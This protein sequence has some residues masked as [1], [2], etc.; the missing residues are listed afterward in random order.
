MINP[1]EALTVV[2]VCNRAAS[3]ARTTI[4][5][6]QQPAAVFA[7]INDVR[8]WWSEGIQ[9]RAGAVGDRFTHRVLDLHRCELQVE[10]L[11]PGERVVWT[12]V[13]NHFNFTKDKTEWKGTH[14][15][16][17]IARRGDRTELRF[18]HVGLVPD[19][20]CYEVCKD[21]WGTYI[22]S[23]RSLITTGKGNPNVGEALTESEHAL[24]RQAIEAP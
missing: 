4:T 1:P 3:E 14:I 16:F 6:P 24:V 2:A 20:E 18:T 12:V 8:R 7:A 11:I 17:E 9:G 10:E 13:D 19:Y 21:G 23:L 15:V 22:E 5:V